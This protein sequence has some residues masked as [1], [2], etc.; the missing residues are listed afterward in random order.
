MPPNQRAEDIK[1]ITLTIK[2]N[3]L[4]DMEIFCLDN[5]VDRLEFIRQSI[6]EKIQRETENK[7]TKK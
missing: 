3:L 6:A 7:K 1:R 5:G 2:D 4:K